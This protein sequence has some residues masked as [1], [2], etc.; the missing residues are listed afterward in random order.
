MPMIKSSR[1]ILRPWKEKDLEPF[2]NLN[3]D[4]LVMEQRLNRHV[5]YRLKLSDWKKLVN[6]AIP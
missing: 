5:L 2:A 4:P 3:A 6:E 1:L